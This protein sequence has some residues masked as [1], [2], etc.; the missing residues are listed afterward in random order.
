M[1]LTLSRLIFNSPAIIL[2]GSRRSSA[3]ILHSSSMLSEV[4]L[5]GGRPERDPSL[6]SSF[7][8]LKRLNHSKAH[9]LLTASTPYTFTNISCVSVAVFPNL[10]QNLMF[11][12]CSISQ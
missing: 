6:T 10:K 12:R 7:P 11:T 4:M 3:S 9:F 2:K 8:S 1:L 5:V